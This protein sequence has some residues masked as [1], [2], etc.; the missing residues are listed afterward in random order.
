MRQS[1]AEAKLYQQRVQRHTPKIPV[2]RNVIAA[3]LV[4]GTICLLGQLLLSWFTGNG[5]SLDDSV[6]ST[7]AVM[8]LIGAVL[9]G[10][11][12][13]DEVGRFAGMGAALPITGF[14]NAMVSPAMEY[15]REGYVL[16]VGARMFSV[17]G[18]VVVYG[19]V[20]SIAS[21][22]IRYWLVGP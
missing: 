22:A 13:Y 7:A 4:G 8:I 10:I 11:G 14:A 17:A 9:T 18:P 2:L 16:G 3:F 20:V 5:M 12:V 21:A 19:L 15:K 1:G 6:S